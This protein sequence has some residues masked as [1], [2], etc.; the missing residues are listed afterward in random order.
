MNRICGAYE[1]EKHT[2][3]LLESKKERTTCKTQTLMDHIQTYPTE[4]GW[5]RNWLDS[6]GSEC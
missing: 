6:S 3:I 1:G 5:E 2:G 4:A